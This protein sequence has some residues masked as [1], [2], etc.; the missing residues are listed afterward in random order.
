MKIAFCISFILLVIAVA[1]AIYLHKENKK[2]QKKFKDLSFGNVYSFV[3]GNML[4][5]GKYHFTQS[6]WLIGSP[7]KRA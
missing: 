3:Q 7:N 6:N 5:T 1:V 2:E 4:A